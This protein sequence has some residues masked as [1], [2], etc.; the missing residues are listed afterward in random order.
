MV[1]IKNRNWMAWLPASSKGGGCRQSRRNMCCGNPTHIAK[2]A[3]ACNPVGGCEF[4]KRRSLYER[5]FIDK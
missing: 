2:G 1:T 4:I 3:A 5:Y